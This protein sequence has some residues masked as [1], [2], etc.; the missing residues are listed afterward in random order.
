MTYIK[1][2]IPRSDSGWFTNLIGLIGVIALVV[3]PGALT[4]DWAWTILTGGVAGVVLSYLLALRADADRES[5]DE[6]ARTDHDDGY[7]DVIDDPTTRWR[8]VS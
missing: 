5:L 8:A 6:H 7:D 1:V 3:A 4:G 2:P